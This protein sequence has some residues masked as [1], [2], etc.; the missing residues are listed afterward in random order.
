VRKLSAAA[1]EWAPPAVSTS[2]LLYPSSSSALTSP[3]LHGVSGPDDAVRDPDDAEDE[4][5][6]A[7]LVAQAHAEAAF[8]SSDAPHVQRETNTIHRAL[9][10]TVEYLMSNQ[11]LWTHAALQTE[12]ARDVSGQGFVTLSMLAS[13]KEVQSLLNLTP[14]TLGLSVLVK[15]LQL[16]EKLLMNPEQNAVRRLRPLPSFDQYRDSNRTIFCERL[17]QGSTAKSIK[18]M[19]S[20]FGRVTYV[21]RAD[22]I[23]GASGLNVQEKGHLSPHTS[24]KLKGRSL[25]SSDA[26]TNVNAGKDSPG[27]IARRLTS[28][29]SPQ[30]G[31]V[32]G[33][34]G[35]TLGHLSPAQRNRVVAALSPSVDPSSFTAAFIQFSQSASAKKAVSSIVAYNKALKAATPKGSPRIAGARRQSLGPGG[36]PTASLGHAAISGTESASTPPRSRSI[37]ISTPL[38]QGESPLI[39]GFKDPSSPPRV[40]AAGDASDASL[41][42]VLSASSAS[43][44]PPRHATSPPPLHPMS[45]GDKHAPR[46]RGASVSSAGSA[47]SPPPPFVPTTPYATALSP[48]VTPSNAATTAAATNHAASV[49]HQEPLPELS[50]SGAPSDAATASSAAAAA[51]TGSSSGGINPLLVTLPDTFVGIFTMP[52]ISYLKSLKEKAARAAGLPTEKALKQA[53]AAAAAAASGIGSPVHSSMSGPCSPSSSLLRSTPASP[54]LKG[55]KPLVSPFFTPTSVLVPVEH[56]GPVRGHGTQ[57]AHAVAQPSPK[58]A[59]ATAVPHA[60]PVVTPPVTVAAPPPV[61]K[62]QLSAKAPEFNPS[63]LFS[64]PSHPAS[65]AGSTAAQTV[66][67]SAS[68][69][70][71]VPAL[72]PNTSS[73]PTAPRVLKSNWRSGGL[74]PASGSHSTA[75]DFFDDPSAFKAKSPIFGAHKSPALGAQKSPALGPHKSPKLHAQ[76]RSPALHA[77]ASAGTLPPPLLD[78]A[79]G[80]PPPA[81]TG[82]KPPKGK[83]AKQLAKNSS[84]ASASSPHTAEGASNGNGNGTS[85]DSESTVSGSSA[86]V[87]ERRPSKFDGERPKFTLTRRPSAAGA[88]VTNAAPTPTG[89]PVGG[90]SSSADPSSSVSRQVISRFALGPESVEAVGFAGRGRPMSNRPHTTNA[91]TTLP[92]AGSG[93]PL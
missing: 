71:A 32:T 37:R 92:P 16:S 44:V 25:S 80:L 57:V 50:L 12:M 35:N 29:Q 3:S 41:S 27:L 28:H 19:F 76:T 8:H 66:S 24:P 91:T 79:G 68:S 6:L 87:A 33:G 20:R 88:T 10:R 11:S 56:A 48:A 81:V 53:A 52:K 86:P 93:K 82:D 60:Q 75:T 64:V 39:S 74:P 31:G 54:Q 61:A 1:K 63:G 40:R 59:P 34:A 65:S 7:A 58:H 77:A 51:S 21:L 17:P 83:K 36:I 26:A 49:G 55:G 14:P 67:L 5:E 62:A 90:S 18:Q 13:L 43:G 69:S 23:L 47:T 78:E 38:K 30:L 42:A 2:E 70:S 4:E 9:C 72:V 45:P 89:A 85:G 15:A 84:A 73:P 46:K 22:E